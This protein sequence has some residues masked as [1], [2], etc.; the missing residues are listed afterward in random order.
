MTVN[1]NSPKNC[2]W[3]FL[4]I[5]FSALAL[6]G[7]SLVP[8]T[9]LTLI[10]V[11]STGLAMGFSL[12]SIRCKKKSDK[13]VGIVCLIISFFAIAIIPILPWVCRYIYRLIFS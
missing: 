6:L 2:H 10:A 8:W 4:A 7:F 11:A 13:A 5:I 9:V 3:P 12:K 1:N